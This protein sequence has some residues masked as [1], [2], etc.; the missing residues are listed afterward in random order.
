MFRQPFPAF[1]VPCVT[2]FPIAVPVPVAA[3]L[4][5]VTS[6]TH[7]YATTDPRATTGGFNAPAASITPN[8]LNLRIGWD[9]EASGEPQSDNGGTERIPASGGHDLRSNS[10]SRDAG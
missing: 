10:P 6:S 9:E 2:P 1:G 7:T 3:P 8:P 5:P 4:P